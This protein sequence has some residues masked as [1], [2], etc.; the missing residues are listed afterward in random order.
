MS[1]PNAGEL[2]ML[3]RKLRRHKI[4]LMRLQRIASPSIWEQIEL[5]LEVL[6]VSGIQ[7]KI[8]KLINKMIN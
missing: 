3:R 6:N 1:Y 2:S 8:D 4:K 7:D 5:R